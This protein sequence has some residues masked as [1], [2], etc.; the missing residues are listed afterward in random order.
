M[1]P[2]NIS[3][4]RLL[5]IT[6]CYTYSSGSFYPLLFQPRFILIFLTI[7]KIPITS[8]LLLYFIIQSFS[9]TFT[10]TSRLNENQPVKSP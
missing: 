3:S 9:F 6:K 5:P 2:S 10:T 7:L 1:E 4:N 8:H